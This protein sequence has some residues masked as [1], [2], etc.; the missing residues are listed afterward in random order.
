MAK[1]STLS[2]GLQDRVRLARVLEEVFGAVS[3]TVAA[4]QAELLSPELEPGERLPDTELEHELYFRLLRRRLRRAVEAEHAYRRGDIKHRELKRQRSQA[5]S[6]L[7]RQV[8]GLR[9]IVDLA[10]GK[11][12]SA[13]L[14][15]I[16]GRTQR[17]QDGI[18]SQAAD[19][20]IRL[21]ALTLKD[22]VIAGVSADP[23]VWRGMIEPAYVRLV[24]LRKD[25]LKQEKMLDGLLIDKDR[26]FALFDDV[27]RG[28]IR[29]AEGQCQLVGRKD[30]AKRVRQFSRKRR[31]PGPK[32]K[33]KAKKA[34]KAS[35]KTKAKKK[36]GKKPKDKKKERP[37]SRIMV[38]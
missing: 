8:G 34:K 33:K 1:K 24:A 30:L 6:D 29:I 31:K 38:A 9:Q 20:L 15:G 23:A 22:P 4:R 37:R 13:R 25:A 32:P 7:K 21:S 36:V 5:T 3:K 35:Q 27:A 18:A 16:K 17:R 19:L 10:L 11:G 14:L 26:A 2:R 12:T 28:L